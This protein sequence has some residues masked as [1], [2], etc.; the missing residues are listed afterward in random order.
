M[1]ILFAGGG[2]CAEYIAR[3]MTREGHDLVLMESDEQRARELQETIDAQIVVGSA[4]SIADWTRAGMAQS[5][6]FIACTDS[7]E[8]NVVA[9]LVANE[10]APA[11]VKVVRLRTPE[12]AEWE[13]MLKDLNVKVDRVLHPESDIVGRI[14]RVLTMPGV[15]DIRD[16]AEGRVKVFSMNIEPGSPAAGRKVA[17]LRRGA[18]PLN[19][20]VCVVFR[21]AAAI[22]PDVEEVLQAGDHIYV[23]TTA[24]SLDQTMSSLGVTRRS[25]V[26]EAFIVGGSE[27]GLQLARALEKQKVVVKLFEQDARR[28]EELAEQLRS[29][30]VLKTDGTDQAVMLRENIEGA[31]AFISLTGDDD[32]NLIACLLARRLGVDKVVPL[33][34]R[35]N[36]LQ[37]AQRLGIS[38]TVSPRVKAA[39]AL[40][41]FIR[42]GGVLSVR[43]LGEEEAEAIELVAPADASYAGRPQREIDLPPNTLVGA[44]VRPTGEAIIPDGGTMIAAGDRV[45]FFAHEH[46]VHNLETE[47]LASTERV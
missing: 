19:A 30:V 27:V 37:L 3:R 9:C 47:V 8:R 44:I 38:T 1:R 43:T 35:L 41:E 42:R 24:D 36:Y 14:L 13:H 45:V 28:C 46:A 23:V 5:D 32:A 12:Y 34:N 15:S 26:R 40:L 2:H 11:A 31:G 33:L 20:L 7:D 16:F 17:D 25:R 22:V 39:D 10:L 21:G 18:T 6:L 29:T 4:T